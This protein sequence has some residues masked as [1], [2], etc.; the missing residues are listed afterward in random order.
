MEVTE[1]PEIALKYYVQLLEADSAN[2]VSL[3]IYRNGVDFL[4]RTKRRQSGGERLPCI[5]EWARLNKRS[6]NFRPSSIPSIRML[7]VG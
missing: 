6:Q 1:T 2:S 7:M 3:D 5:G 4:I